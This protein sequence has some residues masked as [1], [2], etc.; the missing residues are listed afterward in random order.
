MSV[1]NVSA[2]LPASVASITVTAAT[3]LE[4]GAST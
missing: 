1:I 4:R 2:A 3:E